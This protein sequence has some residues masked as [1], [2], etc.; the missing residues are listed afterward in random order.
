M[1]VSLK[2]RV[3]DGWKQSDNNR[4]GKC[5]VVQFMDIKTGKRLFEY[6]P[7]IEEKD[8]WGMTFD[9]VLKLDALHKQAIELLSSIDPEFTA[10]ILE[11]EECKR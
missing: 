3:V 10:G 6:A 9:S 2:L 7:R 5:I 1:P 11:G 8:F 4:F